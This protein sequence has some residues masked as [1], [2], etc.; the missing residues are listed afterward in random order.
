MS[1]WAEGYTQR[2]LDDA[3]IRYGLRF[4][5]DLIALLLERRPRNGYNWAI[6]DKRIRRMLIHPLKMLQFDVEQGFWW[7]DWGDRPGTEPERLEVLQAALARVPRLIPLI[8]HR[9]IPE[10]PS[11]AGNPVFSMYGFDT[12]YYGAT[13]NEYFDNEFNGRYAIGPVRHI[14]FWSDFV[15]NWDVGHA[16]FEQARG[17]GQFPEISPNLESPKRN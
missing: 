14:R 7:P 16:Y 6:E 5:P 13:L 10:E 12:I 9:F 1:H 11:L 4:P 15:E 3:Q 2:E 8:A 17:L